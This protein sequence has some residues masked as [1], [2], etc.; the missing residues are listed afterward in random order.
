MFIPRHSRIPRLRF[1]METAISHGKPDIIHRGFDAK[2]DMR[3]VF[4][5]FRNS[6]E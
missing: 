6:V 3:R 1:E 4:Y 5:K 2:A